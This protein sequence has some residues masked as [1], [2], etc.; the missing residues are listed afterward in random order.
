MITHLLLLAIFSSLIL[1]Y[2]KL[3]SILSAFTIYC[4]IMA[5]FRLTVVF[6]GTGRDVG[7]WMGETTWSE[8]IQ[9]FEERSV[10]ETA[11]L[12]TSNK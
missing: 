11:M 1:Y 12:F 5:K 4:E 7:L 10:R 8:D 6:L 2:S 9:A 3:L